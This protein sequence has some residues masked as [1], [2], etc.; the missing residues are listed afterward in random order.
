MLDRDHFVELLNKLSSRNDEEVLTA[1][2]EIV[3]Q[4]SSAGLGWNDILLPQ[5]ADDDADDDAAD[6][7][8]G[9]AEDGAGLEAD[10][11][12]DWDGDADPD[13]TDA[14]EGELGDEDPEDPPLAET[15][16]D[17]ARIERLLSKYELS[18]QTR[19]DL[20]DLKEDIAD[21]EF[22]ES[23]RRYLQALEQR[24]SKQ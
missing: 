4:L 17:E 9:E 24:L 16:D 18:E 11:D 14:E 6:D 23:D 20:A 10:H 19:E 22:T 21:G 12:A 8:E 13:A 1:A 5:D 3:E 7:A 15:R 2:R